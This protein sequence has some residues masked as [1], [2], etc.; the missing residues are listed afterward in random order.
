M[1]KPSAPLPMLEKFLQAYLKWTGNRH[2]IP[3]IQGLTHLGR[4]S[5]VAF[6]RE[7][8]EQGL[9]IV[10]SG[11][12]NTMAIQSNLWAYSPHPDGQRFLVNRVT[13]G[14]EPSVVVITNWQRAASSAA[15]RR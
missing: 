15:G 1:K 7:L 4:P 10:I 8:L 12:N 5:A 2:L 6:P 13:A 14:G 11:L 3:F 9:A